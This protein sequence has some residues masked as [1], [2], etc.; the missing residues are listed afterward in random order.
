MPYNNQNSEDQYLIYIGRLATGSGIIGMIAALIIS[1]IYSFTIPGTIAFIFFGGYV[2]NTGFW[3]GHNTNKWFRR[4]KYRMNSLVW[5]ILRI[6][7]I[8]GGAFLGLIV[9]GLIEQLLLVIAMEDTVGKNHFSSFIIAIGLLIPYFGPR[10]EESINY[11]T[12]IKK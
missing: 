1:L 9:W 10:L 12:K 3:G 2:G 4:F 5:N 8:I 7:A 6:P 11:S